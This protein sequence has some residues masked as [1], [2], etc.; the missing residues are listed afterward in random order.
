MLAITV[1]LLLVE[2]I[3]PE[4]SDTLPILG[5]YYTLTMMEIAFALMAT[6]LVLNAY[7]SK[8]EPPSCFKAWYTMCNGNKKSR[9][10]KAR[11]NVKGQTVVK[12]N[13]VS[14]W[15]QITPVEMVHRPTS[16]ARGP[17]H[18]LLILVNGHELSEEEISAS[19]NPNIIDDDDPDDE[20]N[21]KVWR[22][23][24]S[25][26][27]RFFFWLFFLMFVASAGLL[28]WFRPQFTVQ[29]D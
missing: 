7:H 6:I 8:S 11:N 10:Q 22:H 18:S 5:I 2:E 28:V 20:D 3:V 23:V 4:K 13:V 14:S 24:A 1:F 12:K 19:R 16:S 29:D 17:K 9:P 25:S 21:S 26:C 15:E 27:D